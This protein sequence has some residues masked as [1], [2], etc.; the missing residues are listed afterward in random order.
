MSVLL[1]AP[2]SQFLQLVEC[3][4]ITTGVSWSPH[5]QDPSI[6]YS[7]CSVSRHISRNLGSLSSSRGSSNLNRHPKNASSVSELY[8]NFFFQ[9]VPAVQ[10][11]SP[12]IRRFLPFGKW[13]FSVRILIYIAQGFIFKNVIDPRITQHPGYLVSFFSFVLKYV[14]K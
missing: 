7:L 13:I 14:E 6:F 4:Q 11:L 12:A 8:E 3:R 9:T 2:L 5:T 1:A 10:M